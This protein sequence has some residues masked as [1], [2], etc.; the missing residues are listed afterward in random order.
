MDIISLLITA[1]ILGLVLWLI[2]K[3]LL[4][5]LPDPFRTIVQV[6]IILAVIVWLLTLLPIGLHTRPFVR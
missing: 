2:Y 3:Y 5:L 6:L 1:V 4:P